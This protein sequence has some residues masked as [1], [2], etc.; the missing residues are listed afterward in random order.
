MRSSSGAGNPN[1]EER[2]TRLFGRALE[3]GLL[4]DRW[5]R[6][7]AGRVQSVL[8]VAEGGLGKSRLVRG[9]LEQALDAT[10]AQAPELDPVTWENPKTR[11]SGSVDTLD[12][13][14]LDGR[15]CRTVRIQTS[16]GGTTGTADYRMC[17]NDQADWVFA[18]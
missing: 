3:I 7:K 2:L 8:V 4:E 18:R 5:R 9:F 6:A 12:T 17:K 15:P 13:F 14:E 10:L 16:A 1:D 11:H